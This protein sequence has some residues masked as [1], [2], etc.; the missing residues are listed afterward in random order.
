[1]RIVRVMELVPADPREVEAATAGLSASLR[2]ATSAVPSGTLL[3]LEARLRWYDSRTR[4]LRRLH[5]ALAEVQRRVPRLVIVAAAIR[6]GDTTLAAQRA[7]PDALRGKWE[8]PG[9]KAE[10]GES[11]RSALVR[12]GREELGT[13]L[14]VGPEL[15]RHVLDDGAVLVLF[16]ATVGAGAPEPRALEHL[17]IGWFTAEQLASLDWLASNRPF[18]ARLARS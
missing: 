3:T 6:N 10:K 17:A 12:E 14:V 7:H 8:F 16:E 11:P 9:G 13:D 15:A 18:V 5:E 4:A 1:M 2:P